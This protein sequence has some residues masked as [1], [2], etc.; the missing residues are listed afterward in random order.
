MNVGE[1]V[2]E[3]A[4]YDYRG[5]AAATIPEGSQVPPDQSMEQGQ[6]AVQTLY[7]QY[8]QPIHR[9]V[10]PNQDIFDQSQV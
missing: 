1:G 3:Y 8:G 7:D 5:G 4:Q 2:P 10:N 9:P 6:S